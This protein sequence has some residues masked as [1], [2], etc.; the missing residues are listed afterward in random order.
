MPLS[1]LH[2]EYGTE[3]GSRQVSPCP[4]AIDFRAA[5]VDTSAYPAMT[6]LCRYLG[7]D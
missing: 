6:D 5:G 7:V 4:S 1:I 2:P 3:C